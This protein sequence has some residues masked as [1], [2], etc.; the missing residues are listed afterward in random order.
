MR[1][2]ICRRVIT[3]QAHT[4]R[5]LRA[6]IH[7]A[8]PTARI[9]HPRAAHTVR[10]RAVPPIQDRPVHTLPR[11]TAAGRLRRADRPIRSNPVQPRLQ[12]VRG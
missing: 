8:V 4:H 7:R 10:P 6:R 1:D 11:A 12:G 3:V 2:R 5:I 9:L